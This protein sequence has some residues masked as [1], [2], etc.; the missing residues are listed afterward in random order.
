MILLLDPKL[1]VV[2]EVAKELG[3]TERRIQQMIAAGDLAARKATDLEELALRKAGRIGS[4]SEKWCLAHSA[5]GSA[6]SQAASNGRFRRND[7]Y[8]SRLS[9]I[10]TTIQ[11]EQDDH[12]K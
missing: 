7:L 4:S 11:A 2:A 8:E 10:P 1:Q 5:R 12:S 9:Q 6:T 3:R